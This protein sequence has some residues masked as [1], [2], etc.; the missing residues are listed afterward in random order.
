[1]GLAYLRCAERGDLPDPGARL[2]AAICAGSA[3]DIRVAC[4]RLREWG[5]SSGTALGWGITAAF[6]QRPVSNNSDEKVQV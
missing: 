5:A 6:G 2:L 3:E 1:L 4:R